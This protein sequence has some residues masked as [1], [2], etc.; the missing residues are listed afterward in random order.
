MTMCDL[1]RKYRELRGLTQ[2]E[3]AERLGMT[4]SGYSKYE[5]GERKINIMKW[6]EITKILNVPYQVWDGKSYH[7]D[8][9]ELENEVIEIDIDYNERLHNLVNIFATKK[10][11]M[12]DKEKMIAKELFEDLFYTIEKEKRNELNNQIEMLKVKYKESKLEDTVKKHRVDFLYT[13]EETE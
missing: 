12:S 11:Q 9:E 13:N 10:D 1:L 6:M 2:R 5:R 7:Y 3:L 4:H 8:S